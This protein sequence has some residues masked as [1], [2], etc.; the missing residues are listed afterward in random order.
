[1]TQM[2]FNSLPDVEDDLRYTKLTIESANAH[3]TTIEIWKQN[4]LL[5]S[6]PTVGVCIFSIRFDLFDLSLNKMA[7]TSVTYSADNPDTA[8][9]PAKR[10]KVN[11]GPT[12]GFIEYLNVPPSAAGFEPINVRLGFGFSFWPGSHPWLF[13]DIDYSYPPP[14]SSDPGHYAWQA[15]LLY[16]R[17]TL[18]KTAT[19]AGDARLLGDY[20]LLLPSGD[21]GPMKNVTPVVPPSVIDIMRVQFAALFKTEVDASNVSYAQGFALM[22]DDIRGHHKNVIFTP[23]DDTAELSFGMIPPVHLK[24]RQYV[25][26]VHP[27]RA[28]Y[29]FGLSQADALGHGFGRADTNYRLRAFRVNAPRAGVPADWRDVANLY[30]KTITG[31]GARQQYFFTKSRPRAATAA[32]PIDNM[33]PHTV[34]CN[35]ALDGPISPGLI[36]PRLPGAWLELHPVKLNNKTDMRAPGGTGNNPNEPLQDALNRIRARINRPDQ[37]VRLE[38]QLWG[39]EMGGFYQYYGGFP[40][41]TDVLNNQAGRLRTVLQKLANAAISTSITTA[42]I[43]PY[44]NHSRFGGHLRWTGGTSKEFGNPANWADW[45]Q[46]PFPAEF[47]R[48]NSPLSTC[49]LTEVDITQP[50]PGRHLKRTFIVKDYPAFTQHPACVDVEAL[51]KNLDQ[52]QTAGEQRLGGDGMRYEPPKDVG[53][54]NRFYGYQTLALCPTAEVVRRYGEEWLPKVFSSGA[55]LVEFMLIGWEL[56]IWDLCYNKDHQHLVPAPEAGL[57]LAYD[58]VIGCG[59]WAV[60]RLQAVCATAYDVAAAQ[61]VADFALTI[62]GAPVEPLLPFVNEFYHSSPLVQ[63][64]YAEVVSAKMD[65]GGNPC[66][67]MPGYQEQRKLINNAPPK[68]VPAS[69]ARPAYMIDN[70]QR[71]TE[72]APTLQN[73]LAACKKYFSDYF[74]I[75]SYGLAPRFYP[76]GPSKA[77]STVPAPNPSNPLAPANP[78]TQTNPPTYTYCRCVQDVFNLRARIFE[79][80]ERAVVGERI[81]VRDY[82]FVKSFGHATP[83]DFY[84]YNEELINVMARAVQMQVQEAAYFR[85]GRMIGRTGVTLSTAGTKERVFALR[86]GYRVFDDVAPLM[87][88]L[89]VAGQP[90]PSKLMDFLSSGYDK[91]SFLVSAD[92]LPHMV[93]ERQL[94]VNDTRYLYVFGHVGNT[95]LKFRFVYGRGLSTAANWGKIIRVFDGRDPSGCDPSGAAAATTPAAVSQGDTESIFET[96]PL[97]PRSFAVVE[98][99]TI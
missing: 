58:N 13:L 38:A 99:R 55:K 77:G 68:N 84:D 60:S 88:K 67:V 81:M 9:D 52:G 64:V 47:K 1:M 50:A 49:A 25:E 56:G 92:R 75:K 51:V 82:Y 5:Y 37:S 48:A 91:N 61:G 12:Q 26:P 30:R 4:V 33:S 41:I 70:A 10:M 66:Y 54:S 14:F 36:D 97:A 95:P 57:N 73:W 63:Y 21:R 7:G 28:G 27:N 87:K 69:I 72:T 23:A 93:W 80:G 8:A 24:A 22:A 2:S 3:P 45:I 59:A 20:S 85:G 53:V 96:K 42:P 11:E 90:P 94:D 34:I 32:A 39:F 98:L 83:Y 71:D 44:F 19:A 65:L 18:A 46:Y 35:Y 17:I 40:P 62:E 43:L 15:T 78:L 79:V 16:P 6:V 86:A 29:A 31:L 74:Q 89:K 76:T